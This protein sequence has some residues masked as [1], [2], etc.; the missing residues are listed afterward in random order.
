MIGLK[1]CAIRTSV[2]V[3][4]DGY[5]AA[6]AK[7][8]SC[9]VSFLGQ[10]VPSSVAIR[11]SPMKFWRLCDASMGRCSEAGPSCMDL[12]PLL[13]HL[14][15]AEPLNN[16]ACHCIFDLRLRV[17]AREIFAGEPRVK[18]FTIPSLHLS[19]LY[20]NTPGWWEYL[21]ESWLLFVLTLPIFAYFQ[22][23]Y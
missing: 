2:H 20:V 1:S 5:F 15:V 16:W 6:G 9:I 11:E 23:T 17:H 18:M 8:K 21:E 19:S 22:G 4:R 14:Y 13:T 10:I 12:C 3:W 7:C